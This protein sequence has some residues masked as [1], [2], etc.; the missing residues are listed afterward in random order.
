VD[1][2]NGKFALENQCAIHFSWPSGHSGMSQ[3]VQIGII[4]S[5]Y[6]GGLDGAV[7][8]RGIQSLMKLPNL[9]SVRETEIQRQKQEE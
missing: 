8:K 7:F 2:R 3:R 9:Q 1:R 5:T 4:V 6:A